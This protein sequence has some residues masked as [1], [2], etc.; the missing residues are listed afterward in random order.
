MQYKIVAALL[1]AVWM[2][3]GI[4]AKHTSTVATSGDTL[5]NGAPK[6]VHAKKHSKKKIARARKN[7][8]APTRDGDA[9]VLAQVLGSDNKNPL[10]GKPQQ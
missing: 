9:E 5:Q 6:T 1:A 3:T 8:A 7:T 10:W 2:S 4:C